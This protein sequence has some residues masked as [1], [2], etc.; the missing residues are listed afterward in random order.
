MKEEV[1]FTG[2]KLSILL[3]LISFSIKC[4]NNHLR[5]TVGKVEIFPFFQNWRKFEIILKVDIPIYLFLSVAKGK[6]WQQDWIYWISMKASAASSL[7]SGH[8]WGGCRCF[9]TAGDCVGRPRDNLLPCQCDVLSISSFD[10][11]RPTTK[12]AKTKL[13]LVQVII[14]SMASSSLQ[15]LIYFYFRRS[16]SG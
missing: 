3:S 14:S 6:G 15:L 2:V 13:E 16:L 7:F 12:S 10:K 1:S 9:V 11:K 4:Y 8:Y 5:K